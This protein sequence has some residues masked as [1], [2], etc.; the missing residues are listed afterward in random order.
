[1]KTG[2][3]YIKSTF[4]NT[5]ITL[6]DFSGNVLNNTSGGISGFKGSKRSTA[7]AAQNAATQLSTKF[8]NKG[9]RKVFVYIRGIG[10][11]KDAAL[12]GLKFGGLRIIC[13]KD[14]TPIPHNGCRPK[15][16]R[17]V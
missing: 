16:V 2:I 4:N 5:I 9:L 15:K 8:F 7:Y 17:R 11:G 10:D 12:R 3:I 14:V 13:I 6:A 1:M